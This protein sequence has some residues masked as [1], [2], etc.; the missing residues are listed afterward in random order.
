MCLLSG[1]GAQLACVPYP[2]RTRIDLVEQE[3]ERDGTKTTEMIEKEITLTDEEYTF[4]IVDAFHVGAFGL[5]NGDT[6][7]DWNSLDG[8]TT[9]SRHSTH[10]KLKEML[11]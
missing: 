11:K 10:K 9:T 2:E 1:M 5:S 3:V 7:V 8:S 6:G 4:E